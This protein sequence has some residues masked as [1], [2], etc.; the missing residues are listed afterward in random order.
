[1]CNHYVVVKERERLQAHFGVPPGAVLRKWSM[2]PGQPG[3]FIFAN[4]DLLIRWCCCLSDL[5]AW[6]GTNSDGI[7]DGLVP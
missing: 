1:M 5:T 4:H 6:L 7:N 3:A 2:W